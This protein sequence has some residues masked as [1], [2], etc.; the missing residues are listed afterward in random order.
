VLCQSEFVKQTLK[1]VMAGAG[2]RLG[3]LS[4]LGKESVA[5]CCAA[6]IRDGECS[7]VTW[8]S[9]RQLKNILRR[10]EAKDNRKIPWS[11][12]PFGK[13]TEVSNPPRMLTQ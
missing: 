6:E 12:L 13:H 2:L 3:A 1:S 9:S 4:M 5:A 10:I 7:A 11:V 8:V